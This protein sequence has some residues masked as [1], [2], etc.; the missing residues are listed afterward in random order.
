MHTR[1]SPFDWLQSTLTSYAWHHMHG[2]T[3]TSNTADYVIILPCCHG[4]CLTSTL[5]LHDM[6]PC[7]YMS[8]LISTVISTQNLSSH[9]QDVQTNLCP[10]HSYLLI[11]RNSRGSCVTT[12]YRHDDPAHSLVLNSCTKWAM[13]YARNETHT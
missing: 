3:Y 9:S 2:I 4:V 8:Q 10:P 11:A 7:T 5:S 1:S 13:P 12:V 6:I